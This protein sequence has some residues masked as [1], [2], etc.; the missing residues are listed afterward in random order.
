MNRRSILSLSV[1][2][3]LLCA[4]MFACGNVPNIAISA[5]S[6]AAVS[7]ASVET[8]PPR[9]NGKKKGTSVNWSGYAVETNLASPQKYAFTDVKGSWRVP[10]IVC[11]GNQTTYS[12]TWIGI[13]GN[14]SNTIQQI[15]TEQDCI[16]GVPTYF[17]WY[18][19]YPKKQVNFNLPIKPGD[20]MSAEVEYVGNN[21]YKFTLNNLT[22]GQSYTTSDQSSKPIRSSAEWV[23]E[24]TGP[25]ANF[26]TM[27]FTGASATANGHTGTISD[28]AWQNDPITMVQSKSGDVKAAPGPL[29]TDGSSFSVNWVQQ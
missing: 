29:S 21:T 14:S 24:G 12:S 16:K 2:A 7:S 9:T 5:S 22:T 25:L 19:M 6:G 10:T 11:S 23:M 17:T 18:E 4:G 27:T 8:Q 13:D 28:P 3:L 1:V 15:G 20:S 26:G